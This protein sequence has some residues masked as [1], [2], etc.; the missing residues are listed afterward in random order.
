MSDS[1]NLLTKYKIYILLGGGQNLERRNL[2]RP[3]FRNFKIA[4]IK[5]TKNELFANFIFEFDF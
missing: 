4:N 5:I 2:E 1:I 3:I